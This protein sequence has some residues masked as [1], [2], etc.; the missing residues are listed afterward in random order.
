MHASLSL[1]LHDVN[2]KGW[3]GPEEDEAAAPSMR[4]GSEAAGS[5]GLLNLQGP[6]K[7]AA[8]FVKESGGISRTGGGR[9]LRMGQWDPAM[10]HHAMRNTAECRYQIAFAL[11]V[12][13]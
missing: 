3:F 5:R 9:E 2:P 7:Y 8:D 13:L 12:H 1:S 10:R 6:P 11:P 4:G